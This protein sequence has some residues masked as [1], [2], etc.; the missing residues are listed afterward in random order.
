MLDNRIFALVATTDTTARCNLEIINRLFASRHGETDTRKR[1]KREKRTLN[2]MKDG[3]ARADAY[4]A[5]EQ[6]TEKA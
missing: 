6:S 5:F 1:R 3:K 2:T 4:K